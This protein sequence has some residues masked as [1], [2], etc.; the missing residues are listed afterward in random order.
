[1]LAT[2]L[3][4]CSTASGG[5]GS[6]SPQTAASATS[7]A[8]SPAQGRPAP[9]DSRADRNVYAAIRPGHL[10]ASVADDPS[11][12]YV[13]NGVPGTVEVIDP[14]NFTIVRT[15]RLGYRSYPE[16]VTRRG[17]CAGSTWTSTA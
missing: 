12:V 17:T 13:P 10:R 11:Y 6:A 3:V 2:A 16:H 14:K 4:S 1:M 15:I 8:D 7:S 5:T 9:G